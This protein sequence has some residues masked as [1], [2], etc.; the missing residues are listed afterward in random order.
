MGSEMCIRDRS[1]FS[2]QLLLNNAIDRLTHNHLD[3]QKEDR[4]H[5]DQIASRW[6]RLLRNCI[7]EISQSQKSTH[8]IENPYVVGVPLTYSHHVF[9][10]RQ[11]ISEKIERLVIS[12]THS[13]LLLYGPRRIGKTSFLYNLKVLLPSNVLPIF[14]DFQGPVS[15]SSNSSNFFYNI[16]RLAGRSI[17]ALSLPCLLYTSDA[18]DE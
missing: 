3:T 5:F 16:A 6:Q 18:A 1:T 8:K 17:K 11:E 14:V 12:N 10:G 15:N 2:K 13:P 7:D 4:D 9:F